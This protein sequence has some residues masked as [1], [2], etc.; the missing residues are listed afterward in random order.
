MER[1]ANIIYSPLYLHNRIIC[2]Y[3][4]VEGTLSYTDL[5]NEN[6]CESSLG[7]CL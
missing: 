3:F 4:E 7:I 5:F 1:G 2:S 6:F